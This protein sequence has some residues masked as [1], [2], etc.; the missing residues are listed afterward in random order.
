MI[1]SFVVRAEARNFISIHVRWLQPTV[2][3][4]GSTVDQCDI[5]CRHIYVTDMEIYS[6]FGL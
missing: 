3:N 1:K 6:V 4:I 2:K 5:L